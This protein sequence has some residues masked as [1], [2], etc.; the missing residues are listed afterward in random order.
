MSSSEA[1]AQGAIDNILDNLYG[2]AQNESTGDKSDEPA[3]IFHLDPEN[4]PF[5]QNKHTGDVFELV[6]ID[7]MDGK[8][9]YVLS[10]VATLATNRMQWCYIED[11]FVPMLQLP[12]QTT[13]SLKQQE[14]LETKQ[15]E[16]RAAEERKAQEERAA[17]ATAELLAEL[18][19][20]EQQAPPQQPK[21]TKKGKKKKKKKKL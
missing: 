20:A 4:A 6:R 7:S 2:E 1:P 9:V 8:Q 14:I 3:T 17:A 19:L 13:F 16:V 18:D 10:D 15:R 12:A 21:A 11:H 5:Y